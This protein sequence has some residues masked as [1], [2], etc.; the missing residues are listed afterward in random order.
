MY[1][2]RQPTGSVIRPGLFA[3]LLFL[4]LIWTSAL[5]D[6]SV[7]RIDRGGNS[8]YLGGTVH[9]LRPSDYPLPT[10]FETAY[11]ASQEI[12]LETDLSALND[13]TTQAQMLQQ[14]TYIDGR[15]LQ[16]VLNEEAYSALSDYA[17]GSG[18]PL[19]MLERFKPGMVVSTLQVLEFQRIGFTPQGVDSYF[20]TR[21]MGDGKPLGQL[22]TVQEQIGFLASMGEGNESEFILLSLQDL[23]ET[24]QMM[25]E[26]ITAWRAGDNETLAEAFVTDMLEEAP[27][28]YDTLLRQ[29]NL[30][31]IPIIR[32]M[33]EDDDTEF[34][35]VGTAH[36]VGPDGLLELLAAEGYTVTQI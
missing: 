18:L 20:N 22:E 34:V 14:L 10:E 1:F 6:T 7:W 25:E 12:Y 17:A 19:M 16:T 36:L 8:V 3:M 28:V 9:L 31:W 27:E 30:K 26:I 24:D 23:E 11:A 21:A 5:A 33:F 15:T 32:S 29:R 35:L 4:P 13:L 2:H